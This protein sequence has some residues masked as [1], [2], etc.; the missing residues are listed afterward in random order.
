MSEELSKK[1]NQ[2]GE[3]SCFCNLA[4]QLTTA[5]S[6]CCSKHQQR[7]DLSATGGVPERVRERSGEVDSRMSD[8]RRL[9]VIQ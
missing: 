3:V 6:S 4:G 9:S 8:R 1:S 2:A 5:W 7:P